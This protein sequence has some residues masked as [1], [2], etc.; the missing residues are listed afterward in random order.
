MTDKIAN[1]VPMNNLFSQR[2]TST[3]PL[4][5]ALLGGGATDHSGTTRRPVQA[6][7]VGRFP[8]KPASFPEMAAGRARFRHVAVFALSGQLAQQTD[9]CRDER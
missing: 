2:T 6:I 3:G 5:T 4:A 1:V 8:V 7:L 9:G